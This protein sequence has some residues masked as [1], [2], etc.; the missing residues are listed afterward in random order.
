MLE[1][2]KKCF[3]RLDRL[4]FGHTSILAGTGAGTPAKTVKVAKQ[5]LLNLYFRNNMTMWNGLE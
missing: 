3:S 1:F 5:N 4:G 2:S